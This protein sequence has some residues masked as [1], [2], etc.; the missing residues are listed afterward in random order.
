MYWLYKLP[1]PE[2]KKPQ[3]ESKRKAQLNGSSN[4]IKKARGY[5]SVGE[6]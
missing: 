3:I 4:I 5:K 1:G 2:E 6:N